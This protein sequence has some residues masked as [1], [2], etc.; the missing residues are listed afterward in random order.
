MKFD[1][2]SVKILWIYPEQIQVYGVKEFVL[3]RLYADEGCRCNAAS[4]K[5]RARVG[6]AWCRLRSRFVL[7]SHLSW[8]CWLAASCM[9]REWVEG[10][11]IVRS[12]HRIIDIARS[13][14]TD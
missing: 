7:P 6:T 3:M 10:D 9:R 2:L 11:E 1:R 4:S 13:V 8:H 12:D 14:V 5:N